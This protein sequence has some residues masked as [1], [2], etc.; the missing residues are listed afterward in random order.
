MHNKDKTNI[1][2]QCFG[3]PRGKVFIVL[4][5]KVY[6]LKE[7]GVLVFWLATMGYK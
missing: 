1:D 4:V 7:Y 3:R 2:G 5:Q 6:M